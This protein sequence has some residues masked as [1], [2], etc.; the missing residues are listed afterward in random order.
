MENIEQLKKQ[1]EKV[2]K[3]LDKCRTSTMQDGWQTQ[4][5]AKKSRNW[6]YYAQLKMKLIEQIELCE[7]KELMCDGCDCWKHTRAMCS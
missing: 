4:R 1:L 2:E 7:D 3:Q 6:D 5:F